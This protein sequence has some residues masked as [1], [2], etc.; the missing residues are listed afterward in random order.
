MTRSEEK[1][2]R[3]WFI[4]SGASQHM[5]CVREYFQGYKELASPE[6]VRLAN[7][8][9]ISGVGIGSVIWEDK[10]LNETTTIKNVLFVPELSQNLISVK[11]STQAGYKVEFSGT[12][13]KVKSK[14]LQHIIVK[15]RIYPGGSLYQLD[16]DVISNC[17]QASIAKNESNLSLWHRR[18]G[19]INKESLINMQSKEMVKGLAIALF[20]IDKNRRRG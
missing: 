16:G 17:A 14:D 19:H 18:L 11:K 10:E 3:E 13:C 4:D 20:C 2:K 7:D 5:C 8:T 9:M 6:K 12:T 1:C 15:G